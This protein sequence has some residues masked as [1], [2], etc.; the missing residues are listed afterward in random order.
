MPAFNR[1]LW[2]LAGKLAKRLVLQPQP[3]LNLD[4]LPDSFAN[5]QCLASRIEDLVGRGW[6]AALQ[7]SVMQLR[8]RLARN[9]R[10][11]GEVAET[12]NSPL[13]ID[14]PT[15]QVL[16][17]E[18]LALPNEFE[19][20]V[21]D[22]RAETIE[23]KTAPITLEEIELGS[24]RIVISG[25]DIVTG[26]FEVIA[27]TPNPAVRR[28]DVTHPHVFNQRLCEGDATVP[29][30]NALWDGRLGD[31]FQIVQQTLRTYNS[32][33]PYASLSD[34]TGTNCRICDHSMRDDESY[35]CERCDQEVCDQCSAYCD[36]CCQ[37]SCYDCL[38][39][40]SHC[41]ERSCAR[42]LATCP[43]CRQKYC[44]KCLNNQLCEDCHAARNEETD[45]EPPQKPDPGA[46]VHADGLC[47]ADV[48]AGSR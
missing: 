16:Y 21:Y 1:T 35:A 20:V 6:P 31:F 45:N 28:P 18:L 38:E 44:F 13:T 39:T 34:W 22:L 43:D 41:E 32:S 40:C 7:A 14:L 8:T 48:L 27:V 2:R 33:S 5:L 9:C 3:I 47:E 10:H 4:F 42:C 15:Q 30:Q 12:L 25:K 17:E 23:V 36:R 37:T 26:L 19:D 46:P 29:L 11:L 24:F